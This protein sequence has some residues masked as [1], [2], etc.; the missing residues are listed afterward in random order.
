M[1]NSVVAF[2]DL[3][4]RN[5]Q[6]FPASQSLDK[7]KASPCLALRDPLDGVAEGREISG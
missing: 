7:V 6:H 1:R 5:D 2:D 4:N 3:S